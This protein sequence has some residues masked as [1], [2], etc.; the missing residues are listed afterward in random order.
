M[1]LNGNL[2]RN[3]F[4][5]GPKQPEGQVEMLNKLKTKLRALLRKSEM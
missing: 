4:I 5:E 3:G 1:R 2:A